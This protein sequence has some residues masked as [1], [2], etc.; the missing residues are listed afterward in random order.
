MRKGIT[1]IFSL[2]VAL[3]TAQTKQTAT[4]TVEKAF[5][6][7]RG[8][9]YTLYI[10]LKIVRPKWTRELSFKTWATSGERSIMVVRA[11]AK[12]KG[13]SF[14]RIKTEG[15]NWIPSVERI[16]KI[17]PSQ[18]AQSWMGSDF[19]N[20]DLLKEASI[21]NDYQH[22]FLTEEIVDGVTCYKIMANPKPEAS[23]V[24]GHKVIWIGKDDL[25]ERKT[26]NYDEEG[27]LV[28]TLIKTEIKVF[29][30]KKIPT[31]L[32][33]LPKDKPGQKTV[34]TITAYN[35]QDKIGDNFFTQEML[36]KLQ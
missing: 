25:L 28:S 12:D 21:V 4:E 31:I 30:K 20:E 17:S 1:L 23:V 2:W 32:T 33:M 7:E 6:N 18:M 5:Y 34:A 19:S 26:E 8:G 35:D 10:D 15:W 11:P 29:G 16:V 3:S 24:W 27:E 36:R 14:L 22:K 9:S 13:I